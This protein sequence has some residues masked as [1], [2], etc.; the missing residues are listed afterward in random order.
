MQIHI[1]K[2]LHRM[3][4]KTADGLGAEVSSQR[5]FASQ[6]I[7]ALGLSKEEIQEANNKMKEG[8]NDN[9]DEIYRSVRKRPLLVLFLAD[10]K[11]KDTTYINVPI[12]ALSFPF[13]NDKT[14]DYEGVEYRV[15]QQYIRENYGELESDEEDEYDPTR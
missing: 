12:Y 13:A 7:E 10:L 3:V 9:K 11:D 5:R 15:N 8:C 4:K 2:P 6:G 14:R 1:D